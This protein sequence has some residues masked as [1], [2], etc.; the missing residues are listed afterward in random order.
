MS[1]AQRGVALG[2]F[3]CVLPTAALVGKDAED[4]CACDGTGDD[5]ACVVFATALL[6]LRLIVA[7]VGPLIPLIV[8]VA[9]GASVALTVAVAVVLGGG[10]WGEGCHAEEH[11]GAGSEESFH[12]RLQKSERGNGEPAS[13]GPDGPT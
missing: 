4:D 10:G 3:S 9:V 2:F 8:G 6:V 7:V 13:S 11:G 12:G 5:F 1:E